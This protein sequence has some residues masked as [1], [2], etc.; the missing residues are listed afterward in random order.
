[1]GLAGPDL[2]AH[3]GA[4]DGDRYGR[5]SLSQA[6][7]RKTAQKVEN[8]E[9]PMGTIRDSAENEPWI[10]IPRENHALKAFH[11]SR[12]FE[13]RSFD[14]DKKPELA[15]PGYVLNNARGNA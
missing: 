14:L 4:S 15:T 10:D 6:A 11:I 7:A 3:R 1:M 8:G 2:G 13:D 9:D 5:H 12:E